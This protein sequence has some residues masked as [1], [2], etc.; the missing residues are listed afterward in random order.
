MA[1]MLSA[2]VRIR[3]ARQRLKSGLE[4]HAVNCRYGSPAC[5]SK[6]RKHQSG[7]YA[8]PKEGETLQALTE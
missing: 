7:G 6:Q 2:T 4:S 5:T 1:N 8:A 3:C